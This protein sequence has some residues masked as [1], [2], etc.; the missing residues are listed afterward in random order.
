MS[1][2]TL[3]L[4]QRCLRAQQL[5]VGDPEFSSIAPIVLGAIT[6]LDAA[7]SALLSKNGVHDTH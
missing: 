1:L 4:L 7:I 5:S 6:E 2:E 3:L